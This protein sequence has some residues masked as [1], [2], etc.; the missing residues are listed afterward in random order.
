MT[1]IISDRYRYQ[2]NMKKMVFAQSACYINV[3]FGIYMN[4]SVYNWYIYVRGFD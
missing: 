2:I 4:N 3:S 1:S